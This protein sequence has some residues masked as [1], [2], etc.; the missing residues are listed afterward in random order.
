MTNLTRYD[1][2]E[3][4]IVIPQDNFNDLYISEN[5]Y[6]R[7]KNVS[8][9]NLSISLCKDYIDH[10]FLRIEDCTIKVKTFHGGI[11]PLY[12]RLFER[13]LHISNVP[14]LLIKTAETVE[15]KAQTLC[16]SISGFDFPINNIFYQINKLESS[17]YY[18]WNGSTFVF[19]GSQFKQLKN[20]PKDFFVESLKY[21]FEK[22]FDNKENIVLLISGGYDSR[23]NA[24]LVK[25]WKQRKENRI[26]AYH[27]WQSQAEFDLAQS[28]AD[29]I[30][31]K[32]NL[33]KRNEFVDQAVG[34]GQDDDYILF[35]NSGYRKS[36]N[37]WSA[38]LNTVLEEHP[39]CAII[40]MG[41]EPHKGKYYR[42]IINLRRDS[43]KIFGYSSKFFSYLQ[44]KLN[45]KKTYNFQHDYFN[46]LCKLANEIYDDLYS[47]IDFVHY[48][49]NIVNRFGIRTHYF[50]H[51][52]N[53]DFPILDKEILENVFSLKRNDKEAFGLIT[54]SINKLFPE[55]NT[56]GYISGN[57][58]SIEKK[59]RA[60]EMLDNI[61]KIRYSP[62][63]LFV[64]EKDLFKI[65][66]MK[67]VPSTALTN[68]L[69]ALLDKDISHKASRS[70][71]R[72]FNYLI[73]LESMYSVDFKL[74]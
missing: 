35:M 49:A 73:L 9:R 57:T 66:E 13:K 70:T 72:I 37:I 74:V 1:V 38:H 36:I 7:K 3:F 44:K 54:Y 6:L 32:L 17:S 11:I 67:K 39:E 55:F 64:K 58:P 15:I 34:I 45:V 14:H 65:T 12:Y 16:Q 24:A 63:K 8:K 53:I 31:V 41:A 19:K 43:E 71:V 23:L 26:Y 61:R 5:K 18:E 68:S 51:R 21:R 10:E 56:I 22:Y 42:Q 2:L 60:K 62:K 52:Y 48:H 27:R 47:R 50:F 25:Y 59:S 20:P 46:F 33:S 30:S 69:K 4:K 40:G 29:K 28:V